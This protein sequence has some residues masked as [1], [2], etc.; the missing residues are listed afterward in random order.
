MS[1]QIQAT[2]CIIQKFK[3]ELALDTFTHKHVKINFRVA[4]LGYKEID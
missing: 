1:K 2:K 3:F 4:R